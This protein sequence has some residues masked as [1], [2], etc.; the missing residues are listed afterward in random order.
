M[1]WNIGGSFFKVIIRGLLK[2]FSVMVWLELL[3]CKN[4]WMLCGLCGDD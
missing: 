2:K 1:I 4:F 3:L